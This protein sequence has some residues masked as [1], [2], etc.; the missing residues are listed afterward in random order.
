MAFSGKADQI[1]YSA[2]VNLGT[3]LASVAACNKTPAFPSNLKIQ[4]I[5]VGWIGNHSSLAMK[6]RQF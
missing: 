3:V 1:S 5:G 6:S 4:W 2:S